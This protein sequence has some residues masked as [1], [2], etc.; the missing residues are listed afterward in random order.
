MS[1]K[2]SLLPALLI[3]LYST[4]VSIKQFELSCVYDTVEI[5][6]EVSCIIMVFVFIC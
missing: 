3:I 4:F 5:A 6:T 2:L 1:L